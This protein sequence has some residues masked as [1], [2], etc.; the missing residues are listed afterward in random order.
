MPETPSN[1]PMWNG[2]PLDKGVNR[3]ALQWAWQQGPRLV[4]LGMRGSERDV[5]MA[6]AAHTRLDGGNEAWPS[7]DVIIRLS[8]SRKTAVVEA[9]YWLEKAGVIKRQTRRPLNTIYRIIPETDTYKWVLVSRKAS[10]S[11]LSECSDSDSSESERSESEHYSSKSGLSNVRNPVFHSS[12]SEHEQENRTRVV[13]Q[14]KETG[15]PSSWSAADRSA[16]VDRG[17]QEI[18]P[19]DPDAPVQPAKRKLTLTPTG[20]FSSQPQTS[21]PD[22]AQELASWFFILI[23]SPA[24]EAKAANTV[25]AGTLR[26]LIDEYGIETVK[27]V[28]TWASDSTFWRDKLCRRDRDSA[29]HALDKFP[30]WSNQRADEAERQTRKKPVQS[31]GIY[32]PVEYAAT[33]SRPAAQPKLSIGID[34][35]R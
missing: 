19:D 21:N 5:L 4:E 10:D 11:L 27:V 28:I 7:Q 30:T 26:P 15:E 9:L 17:K 20:K 33:N 13:E 29:E 6:I 25:W 12:D 2:V 32:K 34:P 22:P 3:W 24:R 31:S 16:S 14:E 18:H 23:G 8:I 1:P 35:T